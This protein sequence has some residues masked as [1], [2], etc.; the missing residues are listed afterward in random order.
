MKKVWTITFAMI[1]M[2]V[3]ACG[4]DNTL[5][6]WR[7]NASES[8]L[9]AGMSP[10]R[11][12]VL[13]REGIDAGAKISAKEDRADGSKLDTTTTVRY[14]GKKVAVTGTGLRWN[15]TAI[16]QAD[17]N[18]LVEERW[19]TGTTYHSIVHTVVSAD[20]KK[21]TSTASG[22]GADGKAFTAIIVFDKQ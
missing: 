13:T 16:T 15:T 1:A 9:P 3:V 14:D 20:G 2:A 22:T 19:M 4:A 7:Y 12:L 8:K 18:T 6:V 21:T 11:N 5:G 17:A 10:I